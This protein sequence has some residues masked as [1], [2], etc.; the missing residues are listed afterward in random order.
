MNKVALIGRLTKDPVL[1]TLHQ[2]GRGVTGFSMAVPNGYKK[3]EADFVTCTVFGKLAE[4]TVKYCGKG[5]LVGVTGRLHTRSYDKE[6][7]RVYVTEVI[8]EEIR[9]LA[10]K[11]K[12]EQ[13]ADQVEVAEDRFEFPTEFKP[14]TTPV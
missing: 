1:R 6:G 3:D 2:D 12:E 9:F 5:S 13:P 8:V 11:R 14:N 4:L 10:T 7:T